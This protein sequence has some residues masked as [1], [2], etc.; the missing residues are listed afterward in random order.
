MTGRPVAAVL[1][2]CRD[3]FD[4]Y[5]YATSTN[6]AVPIAI[7][8][9]ESVP[10]SADM[11]IFA[12]TLP[13]KPSETVPVSVQTALDRGLP[14]LGAGWGL[15]ILNLALGGSLRTKEAVTRTSGS[16]RATVFLPPGSKVAHIVGG[17]GWVTVPILPCGISLG[18][19]SRMLLL[20]CYGEDGRA[21]A[22][23][24]PGQRWVLG[25]SWVFDGSVKLPSGFN[26]LLPA[27][28]EHAAGHL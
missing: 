11:L 14:I 27:F 16:E 12:G 9:E 21:Y 23:E 1:T 22:A 20:S 7:N 8:K 18:A 4:S 5:A 17:S 15:Q 19:A 25:V 6:G 3:S 28:I 2:Q 26:S 13:A 24:A 10:S